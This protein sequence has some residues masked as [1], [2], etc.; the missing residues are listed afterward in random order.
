MCTVS[1]GICLF[2][3]SETVEHLLKNADMAMY[4]A[5]DSGRITLRFFDPEMQATLDRRSALEG[6]LRQALERD[7][8]Q[9][10]YQPQVGPS[11]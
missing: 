7:E 8:L 9:P 3:S 2:D 1:I 4:R 10:Y 11:G 5:K 6:D